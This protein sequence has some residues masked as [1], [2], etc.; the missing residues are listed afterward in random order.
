[1]LPQ[2][3]KSDAQSISWPPQNFKTPPCVTWTE[4]KLTHLRITS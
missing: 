1:M 4:P 3:R 2:P